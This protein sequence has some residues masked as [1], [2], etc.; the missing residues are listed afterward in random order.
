ML[1]DYE[2]FF[3]FQD[4]ETDNDKNGFSDRIWICRSLVIEYSDLRNI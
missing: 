1:K 3:C 2:Q 4:V